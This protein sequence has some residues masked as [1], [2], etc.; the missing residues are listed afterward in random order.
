MAAKTRMFFNILNP[1]PEVIQLAEDTRPSWA[2]VMD[3]TAAALEIADFGI[4]TI[5]RRWSPKEGSQWKTDDPVQYARSL[6]D[7]HKVLWKY[8]LNEPFAKGNESAFLDWVLKAA[9]T[10]IQGGYRVVLPNFAVGVYEVGEVGSGVYDRLLRF[11]DEYRDVAV[12]G[13]HEYAQGTL[14]HWGAGGLGHEEVYSGQRSL[15]PN[16]PQDY[17]E[18]NYYLFRSFAFLK[19]SQELGLQ[20]PRIVLTEFGWDRMSDPGAQAHIKFIE[21]RTGH[22]QG[23]YKLGRYWEY[24]F[25]ERSFAQCMQLQLQW[26]LDQYPD[27]YEGLLLFAWAHPGNDWHTRGYGYATDPEIATML[28]GLKDGALVKDWPFPPQAAFQ[29]VYVQGDA[30]YAIVRASPT[31]A[32]G[33]V[34]TI[35]TEVSAVSMAPEYAEKMPD[36]TWYPVIVAGTGGWVRGDVFVFADAPKDEPSVTP[37]PMSG[38]EGE[39]TPQGAPSQRVVIELAHA[40]KVQLAEVVNLMRGIAELGGV[41]FNILQD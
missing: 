34:G 14:F 18:G 11:L 25:P 6:M 28:K 39:A 16:P 7:G 17:D 2:L 21:Q 36:G 40:N 20:P 13:L 22:F 27:N 12:L 19:R 4:E 38:G 37:T 24:V 10:L 31:T 1:D 32:A 35:S 41:D 8:I 15:N 9:D 26:A 23:P 5:D 30:P 29:T 33:A 3:N